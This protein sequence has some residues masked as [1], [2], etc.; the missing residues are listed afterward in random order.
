M[1]NGAYAW[2]SAYRG[3]LLAGDSYD[4]R[5]WVFRPEAA[6]TVPVAWLDVGLRPE[7]INDWS[8]NCAAFDGSL[9]F[10]GLGDGF[11]GALAVVDLS[12]PTAPRLV[13]GPDNPVI[14][15]IPV[16]MAFANGYLYVNVGFETPGAGPELH[17]LD[18]RESTA[19]RQ[20]AQLPLTGTPAISRGHLLVFG[21]DGLSVLDLTDPA[22]PRAIGR[23]AEGP[24]RP[25]YVSEGQVIALAMAP[26][27]AGEP[28]IGSVVSIDLG[29]LAHPRVIA[30]PPELFRGRAAA[31]WPFVYLTGFRNG[32]EAIDIRDPAAPHLATSAAWPGDE[33][34]PIGEISDIAALDDRIYVVTGDDDGV[35]VLRAE[36]RGAARPRAYLPAA[37]R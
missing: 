3:Y 24:L 4:G 13:H 36:G 6:T 17:V 20:V 10:L 21:E 32:L 8:I 31:A 12:D 33:R 16:R 18:V 9:A 15:G 5:L 19:P 37:S 29:D 35:T 26:A 30:R 11:T 1:F 22:A 34:P 25:L 2:L 28:E 23:L 27:Q 7:S 14:P